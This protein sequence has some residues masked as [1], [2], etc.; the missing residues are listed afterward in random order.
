MMSE[1]ELNPQEDGYYKKYDPNVEATISNNFASSAFRFAHTL[2]PVS[3]K[4]LFNLL[5]PMNEE[6]Y[7]KVVGIILY[8]VTVVSWA[9]HGRVVKETNIRF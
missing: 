8:D 2:L 4:N 1:L 5:I 9:S 3:S 6:L 7:S